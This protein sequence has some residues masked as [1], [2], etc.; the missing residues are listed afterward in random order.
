M[1]RRL[2]FSLVNC[3]CFSLQDVVNPVADEQLALFVVNSHMRSHSHVA[4]APVD[5]DGQGHEDDDAPMTKIDSDVVPLDQATL[6]KYIS[7]AR[8][9]VKPILHEVDV[10]KVPISSLLLL[11]P[12]IVSICDCCVDRVFVFGAKTAICHLGRRA[13]RSASY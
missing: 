3:L 4:S 12:L 9:F 8:V 1:R 10:E 11:L 6:K 2:S 13:H 7:Y 5:Q